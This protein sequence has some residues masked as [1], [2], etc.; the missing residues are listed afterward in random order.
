MVTLRPPKQGRAPINN[1]RLP[2]RLACLPTGGL[3]GNRGLHGIAQSAQ[4]QEA[5]GT[6]GY[7]RMA[8]PSLRSRIL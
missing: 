3:R 6:L 1:C 4:K 5:S 2:G 8:R 7:E